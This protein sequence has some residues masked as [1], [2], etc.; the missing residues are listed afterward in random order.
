MPVYGRQTGGCMNWSDYVV[1]GLI[2][3][4]AFVGLKNGFVMSVFKVLSFFIC[5]Y[6]SIKFYP[7]IA[8]ILEKTPIY[9]VIKDSIV[10]NLLL[11]GQ[12]ASASSTVAV[13]G[14]AGVDAIISPMPLPKFIEKAIIEKLPAPS[15]L[16]DIQGIVNAIGDELTKMV[17]AV[18][19]LIALYFILRIALAFVGIILKGVSKL[20]LFKQVDKL[21]GFILGA[22]QGFLAIYIICALLVLFNANPQFATVFQNLDNS[23]FAGWFYENNFIINWM[24]P[25]VTV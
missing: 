8:E 7:V 12:E 23:L 24:F 15:E 17:I 19:S 2:V 18:I 11:R 4:F 3:V 10:K 22:L 13:S 25:S 1:I 9:S 21:G 6:A 14:T 20:P 5:I 16:I